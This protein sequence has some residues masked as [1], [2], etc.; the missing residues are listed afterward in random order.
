MI[1]AEREQPI[2]CE[3]CKKPGVRR[4]VEVVN[5]HG[6][7]RVSYDTHNRSLHHGSHAEALERIDKFHER[8]HTLQHK[9]RAY[10]RENRP[11]G[12]L[13][14]NCEFKTIR[15]TACEVRTEIVPTMELQAF[16]LRGMVRLAARPMKGAS[17]ARI[18]REL[19]NAAGPEVQRLKVIRDSGEY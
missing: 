6:G 9:L 7:R 19:C 15:P 14:V 17:A 2:I 1:R 10:L 4:E 16:G 11:K 18:A 3:T 13:V 8:L 5:T 12:F